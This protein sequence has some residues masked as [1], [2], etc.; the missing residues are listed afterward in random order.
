MNQNWKKQ[1]TLFLTSQAVSLFGS[2][3]V[4]FAIVWYVTKETS[5]GFWV[6]ML[7]VCAYLPQFLISFFA[8]VWTDRHSKKVMIIAAD[9]AIAFT[10]FVL[11]ILLPYV[12][13]ATHRDTVLLL[14]LLIASALR[15]VGTGIQT[16]AVSAMIPELVPQEHYMRVNGINATIQSVVQ[17]AAPAAAVR[18]GVFSYI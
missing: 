3:I 15:S 2:S 7:T 1:I 12:D 6:S 14:L 16:P 11:V 4:Q 8:G 17:F 13:G 5:S 10:T 9:A 18:R